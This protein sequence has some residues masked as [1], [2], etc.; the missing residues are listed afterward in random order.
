MKTSQICPKCHG[1]AFFVVDEVRQCTRTPTST[2]EWVEWE[3]LAV[4]VTAVRLPPI[5]EAL[6]ADAGVGVDTG[7]EGACR[8]RS[9]PCGC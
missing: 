5:K 4:G 1:R 6:G 3:I 9:Q 8:G 2:A 7:V